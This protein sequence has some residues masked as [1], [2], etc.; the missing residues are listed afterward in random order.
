MMGIKVD[1]HRRERRIYGIYLGNVIKMVN[2]NARWVLESFGAESQ[3]KLLDDV[4]KYCN[5]EKERI[6]AIWKLEGKVQ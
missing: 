2:V 4:I 5:E 3:M 6:K 1:E